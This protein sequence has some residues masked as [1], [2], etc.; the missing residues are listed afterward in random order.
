MVRYACG[1]EAI[2]AEGLESG[3]RDTRGRRSKQKLNQ[4]QLLLAL[5][6]LERL[7]DKVSA[8]P[9]SVSYER[10]APSKQGQ[11]SAEQFQDLPVA[12]TIEIV[13]EE[14]NTAPER[15]PESPRPH[16]TELRCSRG[17][18]PASIKAVDASARLIVGVAMAKYADHLPLHP[19]ELK[20]E[21]WGTPCWEKPAPIFSTNRSVSW[22][23]AASA[24][25]RSTTTSWRMPFAPRR[26]ARRTGTLSAAPKR[27][28]NGRSF[29]K[30]P[31]PAAATGS[32]PT[33]ICAMCSPGCHQ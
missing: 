26:L 4:G 25:P 22:R 14:V 19:Q 31:P 23:I 1:M 16:R 18:L 15:S 20:F 3:R 5:E 10:R 21:R 17:C 6:K 9:Q 29:I 2:E 8:K 32:I 11:P 7:E 13:P 28:T 27:A 30:S 33:T 12:K 24:T